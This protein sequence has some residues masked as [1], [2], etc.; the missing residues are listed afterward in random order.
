MK[1]RIRRIKDRHR[2]RVKAIRDSS[3]GQTIIQ[4]RP[5]QMYIR[6]DRLREFIRFCIVGG[7]CAVIDACIFYIVRLF[8]PY[9]IALVSGYVLSL[10]V[11]YYLTVKWTFKVGASKSNAFGIIMAHLFNLFIVRMGLMWLFVDTMQI[12]DS[13]AYLP[14]A[15]IS[16]VSNFL[17]VKLAVNKT[18]K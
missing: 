6:N 5:V 1:K 8:A 7:M 10:C 15:V 9:Q 14:M 17:V 4:S 16:A 18:S 12:P 3:T 11:N 13:I 2:A